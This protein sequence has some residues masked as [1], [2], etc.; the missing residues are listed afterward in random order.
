M[1]PNILKR[2]RQKYL[3]K[4]LRRN[5]HRREI[6]N[7]NEVNSIGIVFHIE[8]EIKWKYLY[9]IVLELERAG[10]RVFMIGDCHTELNY[11]ITHSHTT[12]CHDKEDFDMWGIP[13]G[14]AVD[15]FL[16]RHYD[17]LIDT[18]SGD[19]FFSK[20]IDFKADT[21][22][23]ISYIDDES[24]GTNDNLFDMTI[25]GTGEVDLPSFFENVCNYL[26]M[27]QK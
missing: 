12:V 10:K 20:Y 6:K 13:C 8:D 15:I 11:I 1:V 7:I 22:L 18:T 5:E 16:E 25:H 27:I 23:T 24:T 9:A 4:G 3:L 17:I 26:Q 14:N 21:N 19:S 2:I